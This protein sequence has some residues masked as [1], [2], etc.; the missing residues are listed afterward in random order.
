MTPLLAAL[1]L[2]LAAPA[3]APGGLPF[4]SDDY[5]KALAEARARSVPLVV[6]VWAPW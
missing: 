1:A 3:A 2:T 6:D 4:V 5:Q